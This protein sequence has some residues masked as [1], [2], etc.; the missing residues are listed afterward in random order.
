MCCQSVS[1]V[2]N[3]QVMLRQPNMTPI[4]KANMLGT[5][6]HGK[7]AC[8]SVRLAAWLLRV[9]TLAS[10]AFPAPS[11]RVSSYSMCR[12][13]TLF[14]GSWYAVDYWFFQRDVRPVRVVSNGDGSGMVVITLCN[15]YC[16][17]C[18]IPC[19]ITIPYGSKK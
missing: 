2:D 14:G 5:A 16:K 13:L 7:P 10:G 15:M 11:L 9:R 12:L 19:C 6:V 1:D 8:L 18:L 3:Y 4:Q 17:G